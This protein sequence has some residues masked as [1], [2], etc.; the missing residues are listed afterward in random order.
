MAMENQPCIVILPLKPSSIGDFPLLSLISQRV[1]LGEAT[2]QLFF[3][4][5]KGINLNQLRKKQLDGELTLADAC[6]RLQTLADL[7]SRFYFLH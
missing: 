1:K 6:K 2:C 7:N 4:L 3:C 5:G